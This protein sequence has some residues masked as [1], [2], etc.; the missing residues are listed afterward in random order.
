MILRIFKVVWFFSLMAASVVLFY[1][2]ASLPDPVLLVKGETDLSVS[3]EI[4]FYAVLLPL[5]LFNLLVFVFR[6][7]HFLD[8]QENF[9]SWFY[10]VVI[11]F[12]LFFVVSVSFLSLYNSGERF[13]YQSIGLIIYGSIILLLAWSCAWP[14]Y[15]T[16]KRISAK[17]TV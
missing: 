7:L 6:R 10:G 15:A 11:C 1:V 12:N 9:V 17:R 2:Y 4:V 3:R 8:S 5:S 13:D 14:V 16:Y